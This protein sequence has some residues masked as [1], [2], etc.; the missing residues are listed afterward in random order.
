MEL[1]GI[2]PPKQSAAHAGTSLTPL[3]LTSQPLSRDFI[4]S[5]NW[6]QTT[7]IGKRFKYGRMN[8]TDKTIG[9]RNFTKFGDMM[10]DRQ[11]YARELGNIA[12]SPEHAA[13]KEMLRKQLA[14]WETQF[15][16]D[17]GKE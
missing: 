2:T 5:E 13:E 7:I 17:A 1:R 10:F 11:N 6:S 15:P 9:K 16:G 8:D 14:Q 3:L 4:I 12:A